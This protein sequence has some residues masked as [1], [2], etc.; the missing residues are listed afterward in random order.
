MIVSKKNESDKN[1]FAY[2]WNDFLFAREFEYE[3]PLAPDEMAAALSAMEK[4][5]HRSWLLSF[6]HLK[7]E[8]EFERHSDKVINFKIQVKE[9]EKSKWNMGFNFHKTEGSLIANPDTGM[10]TI[11]GQTRFNSETYLSMIFIVL[12]NIFTASLDFGIMGHLFW[13]GMLFL[14]WLGLYQERNALADRLDDV[15]M[16]A[17]SERSLAILDGEDDMEEAETI[18]ASQRLMESE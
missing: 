6:A 14:V 9:D 13:A 15:I 1:L 7:D 12:V 8:V 4:I 18:V 5:P 2:L 10:T 11:K 3:S 17:K 16:H